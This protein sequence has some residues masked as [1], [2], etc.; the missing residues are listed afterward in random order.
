VENADRLLAERA[1]EDTGVADLPDERARVDAFERDDALAG[2]PLGP[3]RPRLP[4]HDSLGLYALR[5]MAA[6]VDAVVADQ[7][8]GEAEDLRD[9]ARIGR[10]LLVAGH[11]GREARLTGGDSRRADGEAGEDAAVL[12]D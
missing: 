5:L 10:G 2:E 11:R 12:Q 1:A 7:G 6:R 9:V 3:R 4:H 8:I